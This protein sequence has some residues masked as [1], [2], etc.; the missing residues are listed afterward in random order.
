[1]Q[2]Y[3]SAI[4]DH[5]T[6]KFRGAMF[7]NA[8]T[9]S[10]AARPI[11]SVST[12]KVYG[13]AGEAVE[14]IATAF[15]ELERVPVTSLDIPLELIPP[16]GA[17]VVTGVPHIEGTDPFV[18]MK[19]DDRQQWE[20]CDLSLAQVSALVLRGVLEHDASSGD[21]P[22]LAY[23]YNTYVRRRSIEGTT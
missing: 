17:M 21:D 5:Q 14:A 6:G 7:R 11:L 15:P 18:E 20:P 3:V 16:V 1:M 9:P 13:T 2:P 23:V 19:L 8:P 4:I 12:D 10:G 22:A